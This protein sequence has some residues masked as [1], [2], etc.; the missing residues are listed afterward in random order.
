MSTM[1]LCRLG[2]TLLFYRRFIMQYPKPDPIRAVP[3]KYVVVRALVLCVAA[4]CVSGCASARTPGEQFRKIMADLDKECRKDHLGPYQTSPPGNGVRDS[5]CDILFLKPQDPLATPEGRF[6]HSIQLPP[7]YDKLKEVYR[8]GMNSDEYFKAL[9]EAEAGEFIFKTVENVETIFDLRPRVP[10]QNYEYQHLFVMEDPYGYVA[11]E[12]QYSPYLYVEPDRYKYYERYVMSDGDIKVQRFFGYNGRKRET[13]KSTI[14]DKRAAKYGFT[15]RRISRPNDREL[16]IAGG[17]LL[18]LNLETAE[19]LG[20]RRGFA[21][22][23]VSSVNRGAN[24]EFT[25]TCPKYE[26]RGGRSK[27]FD[28]SYWFIGKVLRSSDFEIHF[29]KLR[30]E[31]PWNSR[32]ENK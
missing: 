17:E 31:V 13:L 14:V 28:F 10:I 27:D 24:W 19:L 25:P 6:A 18:V 21:K 4:L 1:Q 9:C 3:A 12:A 26:Y 7:P 32:V 5:S 8:P 23:Y 2:H 15:W 30:G 20:F 22:T 29:K 11:G 16:G